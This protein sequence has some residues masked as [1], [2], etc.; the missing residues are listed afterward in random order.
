MFSDQSHYDD[1]YDYHSDGSEDTTECGTELYNICIVAIFIVGTFSNVISMYIMSKPS[2]RK[3][4]YSASLSWLAMFNILSLLSL[5]VVSIDGLLLTY[6]QISVEQMMG[7][8]ACKFYRF[9]PNVIQLMDHWLVVFITLQRFI[10]ICTPQ[11][12]FS[13]IFS[14]EYSNRVFTCLFF[15]VA[16]IEAWRLP[17]DTFM[18]AP[19][20]C[21]ADALMIYVN[22]D[23]FLHQL[24]LLF[25]LPAL[26]IASL[27]S[28]VILRLYRDDR[29]RKQ[30]LMS[31]H[32]LL[33]MVNREKDTTTK[34][35]ILR[36]LIG[37]G[38][39]ENCVDYDNDLLREVAPSKQDAS[40]PL[41]ARIRKATILLLALTGAFWVYIMPQLLLLLY[42]RYIDVVFGFIEGAHAFMRLCKAMN[43]CQ[44]LAAFACADNAVIQFIFDDLFRDEFQLV[45]M[46]FLS[47]FSSKW[48][49]RRLERLESRKRM[50]A[51]PYTSRRLVKKTS[52]NLSAFKK[53]T[54]Q[55][56]VETNE[57]A[58]Q[59]VGEEQSSQLPGKA[60]DA[61]DDG[62][63]K[64][65]KHRK[66]KQPVLSLYVNTS[67]DC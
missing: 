21:T 37:D 61:G 47:F 12:R 51:K 41:N 25:F 60:G 54:G 20:Y 56:S 14:N 1:D 45:C 52:S 33:K 35:A 49:Q 44:L 46:H 38:D 31:M 64:R 57:V 24:L 13:F 27:N 42:V 67:A 65:K 16:L 17:F 7:V 39:I 34:T 10:H 63:K 66:K 32:R 22:L 36:R 30:R 23:A 2:I 4:S 59:P 15:L 18:P 5:A 19:D 53:S 11:T 62:G 26:V 50:K 28:A 43:V 29:S 8:W 3:R 6:K 58:Y 55:T 48:K 9:I 40:A